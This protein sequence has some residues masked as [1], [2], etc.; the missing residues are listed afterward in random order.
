MACEEM[1]F[2]EMAEEQGFPKRL[3]YDLGTVAHVVGV[4]YTTL[5]EECKAGRL[6]YHLPHGRRQ[7]RTFRPEWVDEWIREGTR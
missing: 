1:T 2:A 3:L 7:G 5:T 4:P 6:K